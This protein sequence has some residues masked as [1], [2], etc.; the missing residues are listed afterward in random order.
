M[1]Y[2]H[3]I[4]KMTTITLDFETVCSQ[5]VEEEEDEYGSVAGDEQ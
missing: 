2:I 3:L 4:I 5:F 1:D